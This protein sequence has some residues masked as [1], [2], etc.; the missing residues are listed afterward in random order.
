MADVFK[1][2][3]ECQLSNYDLQKAVSVLCERIGKPCRGLRQ[4]LDERDW[5]PSARASLLGRLASL[6]HQRSC[7]DL[8]AQL[9]LPLL[10]E[11]LACSEQWTSQR[12]HQCLT[13][14]QLVARYPTAALFVDAC[15]EQCDPAPGCCWSEGRP[16]EDGG[17]DAPPAK[18]PRG[19]GLPP[20]HGVRCCWQLLRERPSHLA[21]RY[22]VQ[23]LTLLLSL[24][25][26]GQRALL[27][28]LLPPEQILLMDLRLSTEAAL[29]TLRPP[30]WP[31]TTSSPSRHLAISDLS[32][33]VTCVAGLLLPQRPA[34]GKVQDSP[35]PDWW[36]PS[37]ERALRCL[38]ECVARGRP[39]LLRGPV[40]AGKSSLVRWLAHRLRQPLV[41]VQ[42]GDQVD[43]HTLVGGYVCSQVA[44]QFAWREGPLARALRLPATETKCHTA[45]PLEQGCWLL[46]EDLERASPDVR[47]AVP[48]LPPRAAGFQLVATHREAGHL[49]TLATEALWTNVYLQHPSRAELYEVGSLGLP[50]WDKV[51]PL[52]S[53]H[54]RGAVG[55]LST[56]LFVGATMDLVKLCRRLTLRGFSLEGGR[57]AAESAFQDA[58]DCLCQSVRDPAKREALAQQ[59]GGLLGLTKSEALF[60]CT[61][62]KPEVKE[63]ASSLTVGRVSLPRRKARS[64]RGLSSAAKG[65]TTFAGTRHALVLMEQ[66]AAAVAN[67]EPV[68]LV[69]ETGV[70]K[71]AAVQHLAELTGHPLVVLNMSQQSDSSDLLG[72]FKPVD[73][74]LLLSPLREQFEAL[75]STTF[76]QA[77]NAK[78]LCHITTC[79]AGRRWRELFRLMAH[80]QKS[81]VTR[82]QNSGQ[83]P[84]QLERW[85]A[86]G[87]QV[88]K[89]EE[90]VRQ[91]ENRL[92]FA[93]VEGALVRA[94]HE[95]SW[96]LLDEINLAEGE[97]LESLAPVLDGSAPVLF[98]RGDHEPLER[99]PEFRL[100]AC[101]NPATDVGKKDLPAGIRSRFTEVYLEEP[102]EARDL[103]LVAGAYLGG[104]GGTA[105]LQACVSLY[106]DLRR[107]AHESLADG[108][109]SRPHYSLR[110]LCRAL[111]HAASDP[112]NSWP[113]SLYQGF[114]L[115]FLT[116]L[117]R[118]SHALVESTIRGA[119]LGPREVPRAPQAP[120]G[121]EAV[122]LEGYWVPRGPPLEPREPPGYVLTAT[123]RS[124]LRDLARAAACGRHPVLLQGETSAGKTSLVRWLAART[125]HVCVRLNNHEHT[126]LEEYL[127]SYGAEPGTGR[128]VFREGV[129]VEAMR[130]GHWIILD[131]LN[132][133][134]SEILEALNRVLD[135]NRELF[136]PETQEVVR[137]HPHFMLFATQNPPGRYGGRKALSRA[138]RNRFLELHFE[139]LPSEELE[140]ILEKRCSLPRSLSAKMVAVMTELQLRRRESGVFAGRHGYMTLRDLF[141]WAE[142]YRRTPAPSGGG[143]YDW[144]QHLANDGYALLAGRVRR[145][146]EAQLVAEVLSKKF[147]RRVD[148]E[149]LFSGVPCA[150]APP[151]F[152]H[153]VW[154]ADARRMAYLLQRALQFDEPVLLVGDTGCGKTTLCQLVARLGG[155]QL[156]TVSCHLHSEAGDLL[157]SLR[158]GRE[159]GGPLFHWVDGPLVEAMVR[160]EP[161]LI[162]EI[163]LAEDAVLERLN[164]LLEPERTLLLPDCGRDLV[165][166]PAFRLLA[167][168]NPGGDFGK[169]ELSPALRNRF[170]EIW[171]P[172][173]ASS[174]DLAAIADH[175]LAG[176]LRLGSLTLGAAMGAFLDWLRSDELGRRCVATARDVLAWTLLLKRTEGLLSPAAAYVHGAV[177]TFL[178]GLGTGTT[179]TEESSAVA[180]LRSRALEML[181]GQLRS[182]LGDT[183]VPADAREALDEADVPVAQDAQ[184]LRLGPFLLPAGPL[185]SC[186]LSEAHHSL[187]ARTPRS[188]ALRLVRALQLGKPVL[189]EGPPGVGKTSLVAALA[190]ATGNPLTR[191]NLSE[192][193]DISDLF[194]A[195]LPVEGQAVGQFAWR[196]GPLL[197]AMREGHWVLLDELNL[198]SQ[199]V[200]EG[201]NACLD[202]RGE[203]FVPELNRSFAVSR[204]RFFGCQNPY[205]Q[206]GA[207][208]GLPR[209]FLNRFTQ[210]ALEPLSTGD[211]QA[212]AR[213][214][215]PALP[216][217][218]LDNMRRPPALCPQLASQVQ[219]QRLWAVL[220]SPW[221]FNLRDVSRWASLMER[222]P[223]EPGAH[224]GLVYAAR[225]RTADDRSRVLGLYKEVFGEDAPE[226][227][228]Q[229]HVTPHWLSVGS[230]VLPRRAP[231]QNP[232]SGEEAREDLR[233]LHCA[234]ARNGV[235][236]PLS[237]AK[238]GLAKCLENGLATLLV[239]PSGSGKTTLV[240]SLARLAGRPLAV[241]PIGTSTDALELL[242][243]FEQE[244]NSKTLT[245]EHWREELFH[246]LARLNDSP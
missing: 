242:G 20:L 121:I 204:T 175:N 157:G 224:V 105:P 114:C 220:G 13:L 221:E 118:A 170:T 233:L 130:Q 52:N 217:A 119:L 160:G 69:G 9:C 10:T 28:Q 40:G 2:T 29:G 109:G 156:R 50:P 126:D 101:M 83:D 241:L 201:L 93:F 4:W 19:G 36:A 39:C 177:M 202:H 231:S 196:D 129:L 25:E 44:G 197:R 122:Q 186:P 219:E 94:L 84:G 167:T 22:T 100:F 61:T 66:L 54:C 82:L 133:A 193:T 104:G 96:V 215:H 178:D 81:A 103:E 123:V 5:S 72:G 203:V 190:R 78:F 145:P 187:Q 235:H 173:T 176:E 143:F 192:Q 172:G 30:V 79:F 48:G 183:G 135:D 37:S 86:L 68:L 166:H 51:P 77:Q 137:A 212:L 6:L 228:P 11:L 198:A 159:P 16:G 15:L 182:Q 149:Q 27:R 59:C 73:V 14:G 140:G 57:Q 163:S 106:L 148:P 112:C 152:E 88:Q 38:C 33:D 239:G 49:V 99:H 174:A 153:L 47:A 180:A 17:G 136:V 154:T 87:E 46:L 3:N 232:P 211:L 24:D 208:R 234:G 205:R 213:Y 111:R 165:A 107:A 75:F 222:G 26:P 71:T 115:S 185:G 237:C 184:G 42:L 102:L 34:A 236:A 120:L 162:D 92:T 45:F 195:D 117:D 62:S 207:R 229:V 32:S 139:E 31:P 85:Q 64:G 223:P 74:K 189:L 210:L 191:I 158:P 127:G 7:T 12:A 164:S 155:Q 225:M 194:G 147:K 199:S 35:H 188:N 67:E 58:M 141:R 200:L 8:V 98:E 65:S 168:M 144:D 151:G 230:A 226:H 131:E 246:H 76:S 171:C 43:V 116:S 206:G 91:A 243:S 150:E 41:T 128:L 238:Q 1:E 125:G 134:C 245:A 110:T 97:A 90:Q 227:S 218:T 132:L 70:G 244:T 113:H 89:A 161:F 53:A 179:S 209:S 56:H 138:F 169:R 95:G 55:M 124:N 80:S 240:R 60:L 216:P 142:R 214:L 181:G 21:R 23:C 108:T 18:R 63:A 146:Q